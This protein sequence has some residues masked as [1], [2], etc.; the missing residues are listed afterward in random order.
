MGT[1]ARTMTGGWWPEV[2]TRLGGRVGGQSRVAQR[3]SGWP[4]AFT[5]VL[6][7]A[8]GVA[9]ALLASLG[10]LHLSSAQTVPSLTVPSLTVPTVSTPVSTPT[11][12]TPTVTTPTVTVPKVTVPTFTV[13]KVT[14]PTPTV[15][16]PRAPSPVHVPTVQTPSASVPS[17]LS[18]STTSASRSAPAASGSA[19]AVQPAGGSATADSVSGTSASGSHGAGPSLSYKSA[20]AGAGAGLAA[21]RA[22]RHRGP[23]AT[24]AL[25]RLVT[26]L[27]GC[28]S[29]LAPRQTEVLVLRTGIGL[30]HGFSR[31]EVAKILGVSA[32]AEARLEQ[33]AL[34]GLARASTHTG[35]A[36]AS[37]KLPASAR[38]A[39]LV[40]ARAILGL[41]RALYRLR[42]VHP[43]CSRAGNAPLARGVPWPAPDPLEGAD[44]KHRAT[45]AQ[46][47]DPLPGSQLFV[48][49]VAPAPDR[50]RLA[51]SLA[52]HRAPPRPPRNDAGLARRFGL[53]GRGLKS[54]TCTCPA[55]TSLAPARVPARG[56][57]PADPAGRRAKAPLPARSTRRD[58]RRSRSRGDGRRPR[59]GRSS[60]SV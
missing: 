43:G 56:R 15:S 34:G 47:C 19:Q 33:T 10:Q 51:R 21:S 48:L 6:G 42:S 50:G 36:S 23:L 58:D 53:G 41:S 31:Q 49:A 52:H 17:T 54:P 32:K 25:R 40:A 27:K 20:D 18:R 38:T 24:K 29:S 7:C 44:S 2:F 22:A 30:H 1:Y 59:T 57:R 39:I 45:G 14:V 5:R 12:S 16:V 4:R 46:G 8:L 11:V 28:L 55:R 60:Q 35:C 3:R 13:P 26:Q 9:L 37:S